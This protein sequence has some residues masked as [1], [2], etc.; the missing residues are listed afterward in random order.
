MMKQSLNYR[1]PV[2]HSKCLISLFEKSIG[3][4]NVTPT[5]TC[6]IKHCYVRLIDIGRTRKG[7]LPEVDS[8]I[9]WPFDE[10]KITSQCQLPFRVLPFSVLPF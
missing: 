10:L 2:E 6:L 3:V 1:L 8:A 9:E 5:L 7:C 4:V